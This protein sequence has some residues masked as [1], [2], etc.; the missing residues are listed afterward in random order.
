MQKTIGSI[1]ECSKKLYL[2]TDEDD[3]WQCVKYH[4]DMESNIIAK[5]LIDVSEKYVLRHCCIIGCQPGGIFM[6]I[7][8]RFEKITI[9][10][11]DFNVCEHIRKNLSLNNIE[12]IE[13]INKA[14]CRTDELLFA[15]KS[16]DGLVVGT[17]EHKCF[18]MRGLKDGV[19][20][21]TVNS[22]TLDSLE[23]TPD[24]VVID[25]C[26]FENEILCGMDNT[27]KCDPVLLFNM[28]SN[29]KRKEMNLHFTVEDIL[30][31]I[32]SFNYEEGEKIT[33]NAYIFNKHVH[34]TRDPENN[35]VYSGTY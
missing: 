11:P 22:V 18:N 12:N 14:I 13:V 1:V 8:E 28:W 27:L 7:N 10:E 6:Q 35:F 23:L 24:V 16:S 19:E 25:S 21:E 2:I 33:N 31:R 26:G 4:T 15:H 34:K 3:Q 29:K 30:T 32:N 20:Y 9:I 17:E 5:E